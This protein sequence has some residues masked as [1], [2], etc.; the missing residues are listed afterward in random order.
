MA[1]STHPVYGSCAALDV[2]HPAAFH[3]LLGGSVTLL[4]AHPP[5][6]Q[7]TPPIPNV[8]QGS[9]SHHQKAI[10]LAG[11]AEQCFSMTQVSD[12]AHLISHFCWNKRLHV[13]HQCVCDCCQVE[14]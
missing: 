7:T 8:I 1:H 11:T 13:N 9:L 2:E 12:W 14:Q 4:Y 5:D 10:C 6:L 3:Q